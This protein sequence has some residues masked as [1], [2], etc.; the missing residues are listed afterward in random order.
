MILDTSAIVAIALKEPD[1]EMLLKKLV[2][3]H[4]VGVGLPTLT[5][6]AIVL[7]ARLKQDARGTLSRFL[8]E[9]SIATVPF[10]DAHF[11]VAIDA[12]L[13]YGKGCHP[14]SLNFGDCL[15]YATAQLAEEPLLCIGNDFSQTDL[16][17]A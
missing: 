1:Y 11:S 15:S 16:L 17:L 12:W 10:G 3:A 4:H 8:V 5:E 7:S 6:A 13:R 2:E 9:G 14:A